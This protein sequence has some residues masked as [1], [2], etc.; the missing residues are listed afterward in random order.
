[1]QRAFADLSVEVIDE[2]EAPGRLVIVF[3]QRGRHVGPLALP[4]GQIPPTGRQ[5]EV[6]TIM[7]CRSAEIGSAPSK[8]CLTTSGWR[9]SSVRSRWCGTHDCSRAP[10]RAGRSTTSTDAVVRQ[11]GAPA[12]ESPVA[13]VRAQ[14]G[15]SLLTRLRVWRAALQV[16]VHC[17]SGVDQWHTG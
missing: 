16:V 14:G 1:V 7:C 5:V 4:L 2:V 13:S 17:E 10:N 3:W 11:S 8:L 6:R 9:C 12:T 15:R